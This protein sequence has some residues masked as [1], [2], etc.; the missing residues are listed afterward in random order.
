MIDN[1]FPTSELAAVSR[2]KSKSSDFHS[3]RIGSEQ[4]LLDKGWQIERKL[5]TTMRLSKPKPLGIHLEDRVWTLLYRMGFDFMSGQGGGRLTINPKSDQAVTSQ[6]DIVAVD[7]EVAIAI[8]CKSSERYTRKPAFAEELAKHGALKPSFTTAV[9]RDLPTVGKRLYGFAMFTVNYSLSSNDK[10]RAEEQQIALLDEKDLEYYEQL[11]SHLGPAAKYQFLSEVF[12]GRPIPNLEIKVPAIKTKMGRRTAYSFAISP[13]YLLK[14]AYVSH[15]AKGKA[16]DVNT[17]QRMLRK[18]RLRS[19]KQYIESND[20]IFPTNI[21]VNLEKKPQFDRV[22]QETDSDQ[23]LL[24]W[25]TLRPSYGSA[26]IIDGQHRV[27]AYSGS[28]RAATSKL[29]VLA[30]E[31][32]E[33]SLQAKLF[34]DINAQQKSV[35]QSLLQELYS[36]LHWDA[37]DAKLRISAVVAKSVQNLGEDPESPF[38]GRIQLAESSR[39]DTRCIS[40]DAMSKALNQSD[41]YLS[42]N[43]RGVD[44]PGP[45]WAATSSLDMMQRTCAVLNVWFQELANG[46]P[47]WWALGRGPGGGLSMNDSIVA[48]IMVLRSVFDHLREL[49]NRLDSVYDEELQQLIRPYA[50]IVGKH[51]GSFSIEQR[52]GYRELR[53]IQGQTARA[54]RIQLAI[55]HS[56][57]D[58]SPTGLD[59][60]MEEERLE[61]NHQ[62]RALIEHIEQLLQKS[63]IEELQRE[64][65]VDADR[66]WFDGVPEKIRKSATALF[67]EDKGDRGE[68]YHYF[69]LIDYR[70]IINNNWNIF[71]D[72]L[73]QGSSNI[74]KERR[75]NWIVDVNEAR[76]IVAHASSGKNVSIEQLQRL[77]DISNWLDDTVSARGTISED[78]DQEDPESE[79]ALDSI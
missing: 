40:L 43:K 41:L 74:K 4:E 36:E 79:L 48:N 33:P 63:V 11:V 77:Q 17:Y 72:F 53:G 49:G 64:F 58:Y 3:V 69:N 7:S 6:I 16:S 20:G 71:G 2:Q 68:R 51:L 60:F 55:R 9:R 57:P 18:S 76:K 38:A 27:F 39:D 73:A 24:G 62:A 21:V 67:E 35:K 30:F 22:A 59:E 45:L 54:R 42:Q 52:K 37:Y 25:L 47:E 65:G 15:R 19:V 66:W 34:I 46:A 29:A 70:D 8:E 14:I 75:T 32:L 12:S 13:S 26:W 61:S 31:S 56:V 28:K 44:D 1:I 5:K 78:I 23:G 10:I 50:Q